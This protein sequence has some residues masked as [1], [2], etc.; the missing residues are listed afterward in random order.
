[1]NEACEDG[2]AVFTR[3]RSPRCSSFPLSTDPGI[4]GP[5]T[6]FGSISVFPSLGSSI[7]AVSDAGVA[8]IF[9]FNGITDMSPLVATRATLKKSDL[10]PHPQ[11][12]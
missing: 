3:R 8:A 10:L 6:T 4:P 5:I 9:D 11:P 7:L 12:R 1:M 2:S